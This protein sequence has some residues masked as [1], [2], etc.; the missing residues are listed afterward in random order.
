MPSGSAS[1]SE[2]ISCAAMRSSYSVFTIFFG[3]DGGGGG[4]WRLLLPPRCCWAG[5]SR[6]ERMPP[7]RLAGV[8]ASSS[9][10]TSG[11]GV[12]GAERDD[13]EP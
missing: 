1:G 12:N 11:L 10:F 6:I 3:D 4:G 8:R 13:E 7:L 2:S 5:V 9:R